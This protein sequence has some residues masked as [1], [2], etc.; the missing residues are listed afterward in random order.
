[1]RADLLELAIDTARAAGGRLL[2]YYGKELQIETKSNAVDLVTAADKSSEALI[3]ERLLSQ[4]SF[5]VLAEE[6]GRMG[7]AGDG[8]CW[9][10]DPLDGTTNFAHGLPHF[11]V[12][13][14]LFE[15]GQGH[16]GVVH[17]PLRDETFSAA[18]GEGA[19]LTSPRHARTPLRV[20][21]VGDL[22]QALVATGFA[23]NRS[24]E[25]RNNVPEFTR[26]LPQ[27]RGIRRAGS[28][29]LDMAYVA[30]GR[31]NGYW[32]SDLSPWDW[33]AGCVLVREAGGIVH[34][35]EGEDWAPGGSSVVCGGSSMLDVLQK[36]LCS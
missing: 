2:D 31:L 25:G 23:Y 16:L 20:R 19:W 3:L 4:S 33:G 30:A 13:I 12:V 32:E 11:S 7:P 6:S 5:S 18:L 34:T 29:A 10:V 14:A 21:D 9:L 22:Q 8:P 24:A 1:M 26:V 36:A 15:D 28:A 35:R 27:V 17:D